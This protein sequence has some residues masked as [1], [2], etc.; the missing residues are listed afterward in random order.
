MERYLS[1]VYAARGRTEMTYGLALGPRGELRLVF[2]SDAPRGIVPYAPESAMHYTRALIDQSAEYLLFNT[3]TIDR[4]A[5]MRA[6][7]LSSS[8]YLDPG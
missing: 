6:A 4:S 8:L 7:F 2:L 5:P 3:F 1:S